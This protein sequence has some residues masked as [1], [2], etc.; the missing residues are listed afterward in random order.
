MIIEILI[1]IRC[2]DGYCD[3]N[4]FIREGI[5]DRPCAKDEVFDVS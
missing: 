2:T 4:M 3:G 5:C 1:E